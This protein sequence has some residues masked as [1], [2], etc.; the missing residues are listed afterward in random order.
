MN[1][2]R[3]FNLVLIG[4]VI[5]LL[6][7]AIQRFSFSLYLLDIT[8]DAAIF[9]TVIALS[10]IPYIVCAPLSGAL[11]DTHNKKYI[12][13][14]LD[15]LS[16]AVITT[17]IIAN[18]FVNDKVVLTAIV[19]FLLAT[20][21]AFYTPSVTTIIPEIV[22]KEELVKAN[23]KISQVG[24]LSNLAGPVLA[25]ILYGFWGI[26]VITMI[27]A[28]SFLFSAVLEMF[29]VYQFTRN[30]E[31]KI[32]VRGSIKD[33]AD[34]YKYLRTKRP[35]SLKFIYSYGM[36]NICSVPVM[37]IIMPYVIR[38]M[39]GT[40]SNVY[41]IVEGIIAAGMIA[42]TLMISM[43]PER[44]PVNRVHRWDYLMTAAIALMISAIVFCFDNRLVV[45]WTIAGFI[46][47]MSNGI[48]NVVTMSYTQSNVDR[49]QLGKISAF[50]TA[51]ATITVPIGQTLFGWYMKINSNLIPLFI[52][53]LIANLLVTLY[54]KRA[55]AQI[56][57]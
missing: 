55:T 28:V 10:A 6:G 5:S 35:V 33:M 32:S 52:I 50:S 12:M 14:V 54:I 34:S 43:K 21:T 15:I 23:A 13:I 22:D 20:I 44:F 29:I 41:G 1:K 25:G 11:A 2:K 8:Q 19:M 3:N 27:N 7:S 9:S 51:F 4:L 45:V 36:Y 31:L 42:G 56:S 24:S 26:S 47:M 37:T 30:K 48:G 57:G 16:F 18:H 53:V 39:I 17:Y 49:E 40:S 38:T 46:I